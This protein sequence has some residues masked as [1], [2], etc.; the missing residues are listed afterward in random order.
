MECVSAHKER[1]IVQKREDMAQET[2]VTE[3]LEV[4]GHFANFLRSHTAP[5]YCYRNVKFSL[6]VPKVMSH[7]WSSRAR[8]RGVECTLER[9]EL[10]LSLN[11]SLV[12]VTSDLIQRHRANWTISSL[13][14]CGQGIKARIK[15]KT[16]PTEAGAKVRFARECLNLRVNGVSAFPD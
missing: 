1:E 11:L 5:D 9:A 7:Y 6:S 3:T 15:Q 8:Q 14:G 4:L 12:P 2:S 16:E 13:S 10:S